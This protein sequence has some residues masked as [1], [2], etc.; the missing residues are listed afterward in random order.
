M[1]VRTFCFSDKFVYV[2]YNSIHLLFIF[3]ATVTQFNCKYACKK[4]AVIRSECACY[5]KYI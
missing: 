5:A 4:Y 3:A 1:Y 2:I